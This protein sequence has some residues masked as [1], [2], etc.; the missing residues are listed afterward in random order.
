MHP[1]LFEI[2]NHGAEHIP[3]VVGTE[4]VYGIKPAGTI[5]AVAAEVVGGYRAIL[6]AT[7]R[8]SHWYR[9]ATARYSPE[10]LTLLAQ[11]GLEVAGY[12]VNGDF[13]ASAT[14]NQAKAQILTTHD[15]DVILAHM[16]HPEKEAGVG[17]VEGILALQAAGYTFVRLDQVV[18]RGGDGSL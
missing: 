13:G 4:P 18:T 6:D 16:N 14:A 10:A 3:P 15:G 7:G 8:Q 11:F 17:I 1:D 12:S 2:E 9:G 5:E